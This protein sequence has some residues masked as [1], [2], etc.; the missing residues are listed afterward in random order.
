MTRSGRTRRSVLCGAAATALA[1][2]L[3]AARRARS[4][5]ASFT[6]A[7]TE[8]TVTFG[9]VVAQSGPYAEEGE[10]EL[11]GFTLA[12]DHLNG[13]GDGGM[14]AT[15]SSRAL[16]GA[17][18]LGKRIRF[19]AGDSEAHSGIARAA[20]RRMIEADGAVMLTGGSSSGVAVA[21]QGLCRDVG[22]L[23]MS[24]LSHA[25]ATTGKDKAANGFRHFLNAHMSALAL[26]PALAEICG[27]DRMAYHIA[28]DNGWGQAQQH[29]VAEAT[30][31][32]G[33]KTAGVAMTPPAR[34]DFSAF[35]P[36]FLESGADV[37]VLD[38]YGG[39]L[40]NSLKSVERA[41]LRERQVSGRTIELVA[42]FVS[43]LA[44]RRAGHAIAG[45]I[46]TQ[47]WHPELEERMG[48]RYAGSDAFVRSYVAA[49]GTPPGQAAQTCYAQTLLY[50]D[51]V[52]RA[53]SF[54]P[55]AVAE[56]LEGF[57]FDGLGNGPSLYRAADHQCF[58][59]V[60]IVRGRRQR[61]EA[62]VPVEIVAT[63]PGDAVSY[64]VDH[65]L[66]AGG[67]LGRCNRGT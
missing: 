11:R 19:V 22:I 1:G 12:I 24:G 9:I 27:R 58:H 62:A 38:Q 56:A 13:K 23:Y 53:G 46:G 33:W 67:A 64:P 37:L 39:N 45:V 48:V 14:L 20:A 41:G 50:A 65:P 6:N 35:L 29:S 40:V 34:T 55:C 5:D 3:L 36:A 31:A 60:L 52:A 49:Y 30:E 15:F 43:D 57:T 4:Q 51:A 61:L 44:A 7:P 18:I 26:A 59:N 63:T 16:D 17:G 42:P 2:P 54:D 28:V 21:V 8:S 10:E 66:F 32:I 47:N 25:N